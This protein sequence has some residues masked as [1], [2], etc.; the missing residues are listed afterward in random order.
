MI[1]AFFLSTLSYVL[2]LCI[3]TLLKT[4]TLILYKKHLYFVIFY[5]SEV[6]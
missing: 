6:G 3:I 4:A 5:P 1:S 2:N